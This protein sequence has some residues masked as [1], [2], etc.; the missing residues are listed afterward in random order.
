[1]VG[2]GRVA[3]WP[4]LLNSHGVRS[5]AEAVALVIECSIPVV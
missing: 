2:Q 1:M 4:L 3:P 5:H